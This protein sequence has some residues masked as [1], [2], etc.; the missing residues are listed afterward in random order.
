MNR[1]TVRSQR[2]TLKIVVMKF[3]LQSN[4]KFINSKNK[5]VRG[6]RA[7]MSYSPLRVEIS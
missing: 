4:Q 1:W 6:E 5:E 3:L 7:A 2:D